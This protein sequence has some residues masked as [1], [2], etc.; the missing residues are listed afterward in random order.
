VADNQMAAKVESL[1]REKQEIKA[2]LDKAQA[3]RARI[4]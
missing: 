2:E 3:E 1:K 4:K